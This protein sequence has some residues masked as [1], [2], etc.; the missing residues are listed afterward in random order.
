[1]SFP[2]ST[3]S[4]HPRDAHSSSATALWRRQGL[5][6]EFSCIKSLFSGH[7]FSML[8]KDVRSAN[9]AGVSAAREAGCQSR[10]IQTAEAIYPSY[11][12][13]HLPISLRLKKFLPA[14]LLHCPIPHLALHVQL[15]HSTEALFGGHQ[16]CGSFVRC[17]D[18]DH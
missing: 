1:M 16:F 5:K 8:P 7:F 11:A 13:L 6:R 10:S 9:K 15:Y 18:F 17:T 4:K 3:P 2:F 14:H 12:A